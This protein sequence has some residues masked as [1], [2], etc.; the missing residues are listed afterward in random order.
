MFVVVLNEMLIGWLNGLN[1][2][3]V[4]LLGFILGGMMV[5]DMGGLIN[6]VVFM[7]G[8]VVIEV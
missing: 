7:F 2:M 3:N 4:I 8:I 5:I 6:K 1:G